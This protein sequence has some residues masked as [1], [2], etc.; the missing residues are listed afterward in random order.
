M[1]PIYDPLPLAAR[2]TELIKATERDLADG[3]APL[4]HQFLCDHGVT[5]DEAYDLADTIRTA[6]Q[7][8][9]RVPAQFVVQAMAD[10]LTAEASA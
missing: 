7:V 3:I 1:N 6:L 10:D 9:R 8:Y 5:L 2:T 4:G